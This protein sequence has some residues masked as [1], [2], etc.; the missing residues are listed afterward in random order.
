MHQISAVVRIIDAMV[1]ILKLSNLCHLHRE[2]VSDIFCL[3]LPWFIQLELQV[4]S[5][6]Q[7]LDLLV[8]L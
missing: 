8:I 7:L 6:I 3:L 2:I 5:I 1:W 4:L